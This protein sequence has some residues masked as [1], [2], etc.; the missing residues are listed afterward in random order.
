M[1]NEMESLNT[2]LKRLL[3]KYDAEFVVDFGY[4]S[5]IRSIDIQ[6]PDGWLCYPNSGS[7]LC[8]HDLNNPEYVL[9]SEDHS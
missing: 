2:E 8:A 5:D 1:N 9:N 7:R 3:E 6:T 4:D